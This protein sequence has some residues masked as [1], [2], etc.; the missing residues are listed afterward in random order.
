MRSELGANYVTLILR[1]PGP[2]DQGLM[3]TVGDVTSEGLISYH[4][5]YYAMD[6]FVGL[7]SEKVVTT[8]EIMSESRWVASPFYQEF[9]APVDVHHLMGADIRT[10]D[11]VE[12]RLRVC[13]SLNSP[14]FFPS[15]TRHFVRCCY[16]I[17]SAQC[18]CTGNWT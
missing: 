16:H 9:L 15:A 18:T 11:G 10:D 13:R 4:S 12:C 14:D 6:P 3:V 2:G 1:S 8:S 7:P 17:S 5:H